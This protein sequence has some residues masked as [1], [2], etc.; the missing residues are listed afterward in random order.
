MTYGA[1]PAHT[2]LQGLKRYT[3]AKQPLAITAPSRG[4]C[5]KQ[6]STLWVARRVHAESEN[7][8]NLA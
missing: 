8:I 3:R 7:A 1:S 2:V 6:D 4:N 5:G